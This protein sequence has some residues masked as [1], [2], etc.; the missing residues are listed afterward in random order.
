MKIAH[1]LKFYPN[2]SGLYET[3]REIIAEENNQGHDARILD[4]RE[5]V[6]YNKYLLDRGVRTCDLEWFEQADI[7][8]IHQMLPA[9]LLAKIDKPIVVILHGTPEACY[10]S[11]VWDT[12]FSFKLILDLVR[13]RRMSFVTL[14]ERHFDFWNNIAPGRVDYVPSCVDTTIFDPEKIK[15]YKFNGAS[16]GTPNIVFADT[17]RIVK[18]P[19]HMLNAFKLFKKWHSKARM[20]IYC[21][22]R[23]EQSKAR[24]FF[25]EYLYAISEGKDSYFGIYDGFTREISR[26][27]AGADFIVTQQMD[28]TRIVRE[29]NSLG[30][31]VIQ[32]DSVADYYHPKRFAEKMARV[33]EQMLRGDPN[34]SPREIRRKAKL[35]YSPEVTIDWLITHFNKRLKM[36]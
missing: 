9:E 28:S 17:W 10:M 34:F 13:D 35:K 3:A 26:V 16:S 12:S 22:P 29:A 2:T 11:D 6:G 5:G 23:D 14:W 4:T 19:F 30:T 21:R 24:K 31:P 7:Y 27:M 32:P 18:D 20:H 1:T 36:V 25:D 8:V 15:P 33:W